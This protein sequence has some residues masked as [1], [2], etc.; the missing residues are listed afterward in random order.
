MQALVRDLASRAEEVRATVNKY[1]TRHPYPPGWIPFEAF[2][3][4]CGTI[5]ATTT[6]IDGTMASYRC[7]RCGHSG[8]SSIE[9]GKLNWR[10]EWP[11]LWKVYRV[12]IEPFGKDHATPGGSRDSCAEIA[13]TIMHFRPPMGIPY[14]WVGIADRGK[15]LGDMGSSDFLGFTPAQWVAVGDPEVLRYIYAFN[16]IARRVV[17]D[18]YRVDSYHDTF[19]RAEAAFY[20]EKR[21]GDEDDQARS[22]ELAY[23]A[24]PPKEK[25]F[26]LSYRHASFLSQIS[27]ES[28]QLGWSLSQRRADSQS[29]RAGSSAICT[30]SCSDRKRAREPRRFSRCWKRTG[31][32]ADSTKRPS[33]K[34]Q[35]TP[36]PLNRVRSPVV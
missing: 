11:A 25:P 14:E 34:S 4:S 29:R 19:D 33:K 10:L 15:D 1:R 6:S 20:S 3:E 27:P 35:Y 23:L 21:Q 16:P 12:D 13:E 26:A 24:S 18:L 9:K 17:L 5:G 31:C 22:Y 28:G 36:S 32:Y 7:E 2:C 30:W 8:K